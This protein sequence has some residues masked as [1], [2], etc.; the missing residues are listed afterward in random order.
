MAET[1]SPVV[2][3]GLV[4][5]PPNSFLETVLPHLLPVFWFLLLLLLQPKAGSELH[6]FL[7][8]GNLP[9]DITEQE[10]HNIFQQYGVVGKLKL[11]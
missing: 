3:C 5:E 9:H 4:C 2:L 11:R 7:A 8:S 6:L 1:K 10:L